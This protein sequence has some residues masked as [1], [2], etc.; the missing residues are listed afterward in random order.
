MISLTRVVFWFS[1]L[2][3]LAASLLAQAP[4]T[5]Q[6]QVLDKSGASVP[7]ASVIVSGPNNVTKV[8]ETNNDGVYSVPG[9]PPGKYTVRVT[10]PG[11]TLYE[12]TALDVAAGRPTALDIKL[13]VEVSKQEVTVADTQQVELDPAKN[14]GALILKAEDLDM[15]SD[16]PD[17]LQAELLALAGPAAGPNGGQI[18]I[19]GFSGGQLPPKDSIR[20]IRINSNPFSAEYDTSGRGRI[21]IFTKP[22][23]EKFHGS[24][25]VTYSDHWFNARNPYIT[26]PAFP[27][28]ASDTKNLIANLSGPIIKGKLSFF[29]DY[30]RRQQREDDIINAFILTP[31]TLLPQQEG[32]AIIAPNS[33]NR[34][35]PRFTYQLSP[36]I[37]LDGRY[38]INTSS[39]Y[40]QGIGGTSLP[41]N[42]PVAGIA[43]SNSAQHTTSNNQNINLIE[44]QVVN[45]A[46]INETRFQY[47]RNRSNSV[48]DNP[49]LN[50]SV[51]DAFTSG[52]T[53]LQNY[54]NADTYELQ[55]YTSITHGT[56]F[57]KFGARARGYDTASA[58]TSNFTGQFNFLNIGAYQ[59][60][61]QGIAAGLPLSQIIANGGGPFQYQFAAGNPLISGTQYDLEPFV[62]DDW[63]IKPNITLSLGLRYEVQNNVNDYK[64]VAPR[65]GLAWGVGPSNNRT[66]SPKTVIRAGYG[67]F[68]DRFSLNNVLNADRFN[69]INQLTYTIPNPTFFP[70]AGVAIP[71]LAT[72]ESPQFQQSS[73]TYHIDSDWRAPTMMQ[74]AIG[75]D[76][77]LP[78]NTTLSLNYINSRGEH[79][80][81]TVDINTPLPGTFN[82][83]AGTGVYPLGAAKGLYELYEPSGDY[84]QNQLIVNINSR[85]NAKFSLFGYYAYGHVNSDVNGSP[86]NPYNFHQ[87]WGPASY[88]IRH[89]V[90][91]NGSLV[92]PY[93]LRMSPNITYNSAP[94]FNVT[95]GIDEFGDTLTNTRPALAPLGFTA[96]TGAVAC[97]PTIAKNGQPCVISGGQYGNF[98]IN[99]QALGLTPIPINAFRAAQQFQFNVRLSRTWGFG[100]STAPNPNRRG[101][102]GGPGGRGPGF[103]QA[104]GGGGRGGGGGGRGGGGPGPGGGGGGENSGK[105]YSLTAGIFVHNLFNNVNPGGPVG[106]LLSPRFG[107]TENLANIGGPGSVAFNRRI[108]LNLR[109]SF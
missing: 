23:S 17:D 72:L 85:L 93:G 36:T 95:Q 26:S 4:G 52:S 79:I 12:K 109:F 57:I 96:G 47:A 9:L 86:S 50:I 30:S 19:D 54:T 94:P 84:K 82:A 74:A 58:V 99:P 89:R 81:Q 87:D 28:P 62:Q 39:A 91:V 97:T 88:D 21:E 106:D 14:A 69:G 16:D 100:E 24:V 76:R 42:V 15:L 37:T 1:V 45:A 29:V 51:A 41:A 103:G 90:N 48:G 10:A 59:I 63:R 46:T 7:K 108:D 92:L 55:N 56:H 83:I 31:V 107:E 11:F 40:N 33:N 98:V 65:I 2:A 66:R 64:D 60:M 3:L 104:A 20:E 80:L 73:A 38:S 49:E 13:A 68:Y 43:S 67:W 25:N 5:L 101:Q 35:S 32:F 44:T 71:A 78:K 105:R 75:F 18:F 34:F 27:V 22:G 102:D 70:Q 6:G 8:A 53:I 61:E 77:Q